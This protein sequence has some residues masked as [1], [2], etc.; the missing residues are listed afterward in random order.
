MN[1][2]PIEKQHFVLSLL[3]EGNSIRSIERITGIHRDTIIRLLV[4]VG[5]DAQ[6]VLDKQLQNLE[7]KIIQCDEIWGFVGKKQKQVVHDDKPDYGDQWVFIALDAESKLVPSFFVGKRTSE[8]SDRLMYDLASKIKGRFHLSTDGFNA[9]PASVYKALG[10]DVDY[11]QVIKVY[12]NNTKEENRRY[13]PQKIVSVTIQPVMGYPNS[14][15][16]STSYIERQNLTI[17]MQ[18]RRFTRLTNAF[19]RK[20]ENMKAALSLHFFHY[21]F[22]RIHSTIRCTPAMAAKVPRSIW[23]WDDLYRECRTC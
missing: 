1:K 16:I 13:S 5:Q 10:G 8:L 17:R 7:C 6:T 9:Y 12:G 20:V 14:K 3:V 23:T 2:L 21:N 11:G 15:L 18:N 22:M 4:S 19:S